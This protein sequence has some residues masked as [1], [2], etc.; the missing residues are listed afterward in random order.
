VFKERAMSKLLFAIFIASQ[1]ATFSAS[2]ALMKFSFEGEITEVENR[3]DML[4]DPAAVIG[5]KIIGHMIMDITKVSRGGPQGDAYWNYHNDNNPGALQ[6]FLMLGGS[7]YSL[8]SE[9]D[10]NET[11]SSYLIDEYIDHYS[12]VLSSGR[13]VADSISLKDTEIYQEMLADGD[14]YHQEALSFNYSDSI[15]DFLTDIGP[16]S[17]SYEDQPDWRQEYI[18][19]ND[20]S[21]NNGKTGAGG[22]GYYEKVT[23]LD[24]NL[25]TNFDSSVRFELSRVAV[26]QVRYVS[27]PSSLWI[28]L[29]ALIFIRRFRCIPSSV[30]Y[31]RF[32]CVLPD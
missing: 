31:Q 29:L 7:N 24:S 6:S 21:P 8:L 16:V 15:N 22:F 25:T 17:G 9:N 18:W 13:P 1:L 5:T 10:F 32:Y 20:G 12:G 19:T 11:H 27:T 2:A 3:G 26:D 30:N 14:L 4:W 28:M 23:D